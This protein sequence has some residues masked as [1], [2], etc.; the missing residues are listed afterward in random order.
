MSVDLKTFIKK[1]AAEGREIDI[2]K[3]NLINLDEVRNAAGE[4]WPKLKNRIFQSGLNFIENR[5]ADEDSVLAF[6]KGFILLFADPDTDITK[7][8]GQIAAQLKAFFLGEPELAHLDIVTD[9]L[10]ADTGGII[11]I[12]SSSDTP[13]PD[14][15]KPRPKPSMP[16]DGDVPHGT[17]QAFFRPVWDVDK[18]QLSANICFPKVSVEGRWTDYARARELLMTER[19]PLE[20]D[21]SAAQ[22]A[23][24]ALRQSA[25]RKLPLTLILGVQC[26]TL[27]QRSAREDWCAVFDDIPA[28]ARRK[29]WLRVEDLPEDPKAAQPY[30][31]TVSELGFT[32]IVQRPFGEFELEG[33]DQSD[34]K[35]V[36]T[37]TRPPSN[38]ESEGLLA[39]EVKA[40]GRLAR[41]ARDMQ[42]LVLVDDIREAKTFNDMLGSGVRFLA[43][44]QVL[45]DTPLPQPPKAFT[46]V[47]LARLGK[48]TA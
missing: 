26:E 37:V 21:I 47:E 28:T 45:K 29:I 46:R 9:T 35:L 24:Q 48:A 18:Q 44:A 43:G 2:G 14:E 7:A 32:V 23:V 3:F 22:G 5:V 31:K 19:D 16:E 39:H 6:N 4:S 17:L 8:V 41:D 1:A 27:D 11:K 10:K 34:A 40:L 15:S 25:A 33:F 42:A 13:S 36:S 12:V 20:A 30:L 38:S